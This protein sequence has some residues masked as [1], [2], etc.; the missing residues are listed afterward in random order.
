MRTVEEVRWVPL[1]GAGVVVRS[2]SS[3]VG[4]SLLHL[5]TRWSI[6]YKQLHLGNQVEHLLQTGKDIFSN[7]GGFNC[8]AS[9]ELAL[10]DG[11]KNYFFWY[12]FPSWRWHHTY[13]HCRSTP[14]PTA[15]LLCWSGPW[16]DILTL[17]ETLAPQIGLVFA[18]TTELVTTMN[19]LWTSW[20]NI[21]L[22]TLSLNILTWWYCSMHQ[23]ARCKPHHSP[24]VLR[25]PFRKSV[26][27]PWFGRKNKKCNC[28]YL[29]V[30]FQPWN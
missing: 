25:A 8:C 28:M 6:F 19:N 23:Y 21:V 30:Q 17:R 3:K 15:L 2:G 14:L 1:P 16:Y 24:P 20:L 5:E 18:V 26:S 12:F 9:F 4:T 13:L 27:Q 10:Q 29:I 7:C 11:K 22:W